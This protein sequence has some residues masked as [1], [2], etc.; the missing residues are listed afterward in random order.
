M[1]IAEGLRGDVGAQHKARWFAARSLYEGRVVTD[2]DSQ[3]VAGVDWNDEMYNLSRSAADTAQAEVAARQRPKPMFL[4]S[5]SDWR[6]KRKAKKLDKFVE[7]TLHQRQGARYSDAWELTEDVFRDAE[8]AVAGVVKV[9]VD[10][11]GERIVLERVPAYEVLVDPREAKCGS[12]RNWF[13]TYEMDLDLAEAT[14]VDGNDELSEDEK[15]ELRATLQ[16]SAMHER[17]DTRTLAGWRAVQSVRITEAWWISPIKGKPGRHVFACR[18]GVLSESDWTWPRAPF[19]I[20]VWSKEPFGIWGTG[21]VES[22][23]KQHDAVNKLQAKVMD[24]MTLLSGRRTYYEPGTIDLEKMASNESETLIPC[25]DLSKLPREV[26]VPPIQAAEAQMVGTEISRY[27]E[28]SGVSEA[29]AQ[30]RKDPGVDAAI[31]MQTLNDIKS[32]RFMSKARAYELLFVGLG[33]MIVL[34]ARDIGDDLVA[35]WPGKRFLQEIKWSD[36]DLDEDMYTVRVAPV[37][38]MSKDPAQRLQI[39]E[40]LVNMGFLTR[41]KYLELIGMPDLDSAL[42]LEGSESQWID[43]MIDRYLDAE[44]QAE[45]KLLG[46]YSEPDGYLLNLQGALVLTAQ[47]YFDSKVNDAPDFNTDLIRRFMDSLKGLIQKVSAATA[48]P[49]APAAPVGVLPGA[50]SMDPM[51]QGMAA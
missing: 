22:G 41:E 45:L 42:N 40:Q 13:H 24:R 37:S 18:D 12:P 30:A 35:K 6:T 31:A 16:S 20:I 43:K 1:A 50:P 51:A 26:D 46:G 10:A 3:G 47:H 34:A 14:F 48:P 15:T 4:C 21:L 32:V 5:D 25:K 9:S 19:E 7:A 38:S 8:C 23:A 33:E 27:F 29:S 28:F 17:A 44:D 2:A 36:V 49:P 39:V 11:Q